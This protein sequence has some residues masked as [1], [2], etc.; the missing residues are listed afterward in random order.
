[1]IL[2]LMRSP[3][4]RRDATPQRGRRGFTLIE[5]LV[6]IGVIGLLMA[7][8]LPAIQ[9]AREAAR[10]TVCQSNLRQ[11]GLALDLHHSARKTL[12][13]GWLGND[14]MEHPGW[15]WAAQILPYI[16]E[17]KTVFQ[18]AGQIFLPLDDPRFTS[19][20][21]LSLPLY[22]C[23]SDGSPLIFTLPPPSLS[24]ASKIATT[25]A[26]L[27]PAQA[28]VQYTVARA[29]YAGNYGTHAVEDAP[30]AGNG[31]FFRNSRIRYAFLSQGLSKTMFVGE[32]S[33]RTGGTTWTGVFINADRPMPRVVGTTETVPND[34]LGDIAGFG[35][36]HGGGANFL[37]GDTAVAFVSDEIDLTVFRSMS[38]RDGG[39]P[40]DAS[41]PVGSPPAT[42]GSGGSGDGGD[43][44]SGSAAP[45][46]PPQTTTPPSTPPA[47]PPATPPGGSGTN[48][49]D[50]AGSGG[51]PVI[52]PNSAGDDGGKDDGG[53]TDDDGGKAGDDGNG[54]ADGNSGNPK[55]LSGDDDDD[56]CD[57]GG[58][59][60]SGADDG[61]NTIKL[62][63]FQSG[64]I[65]PLSDSLPATNGMSQ[66]VVSHAHAVWHRDN[67][68]ASNP[69]HE[70]RLIRV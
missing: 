30:T 49:G 60:D 50:P 35:S 1:M 37:S 7:V 40:A 11:I 63:G 4:P 56:G 3:Q 45:P 53:S 59:D 25:A 42:T 48:P 46:V 58:S 21:Q 32:R 41:C 22:T 33:S 27:T 17:G 20:I 28:T 47:I 15:G 26:I 6:V 19:T 52:P 9:A 67:L 14:A 2:Q 34:V 16:E 70:T 64:N 12:P 54:T 36:D 51:N 18:S 8:M 10:K 13:S 39:V 43:P 44:S 69:S 66:F 5:L 61:S 65:A 62:G 55:T 68:P 31:V 24:A 29:N 57:D 38:T 23:P